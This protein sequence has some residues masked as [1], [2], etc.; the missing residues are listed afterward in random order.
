MSRREELL[1]NVATIGPLLV[2]PW[3]VPVWCLSL[4]AYGLF[5]RREDYSGHAFLLALVAPSVPCM[6]AA[7][8]ALNHRRA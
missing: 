1:L 6:M 7:A 4:T 3:S 5:L 8:W 2:L